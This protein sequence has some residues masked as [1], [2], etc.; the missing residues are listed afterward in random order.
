M[1]FGIIISC[2][3][4]NTAKADSLMPGYGE[5]IWT[6]TASTQEPPLLRGQSKQ[7]GPWQ[8]CTDCVLFL[9][10]VNIHKAIFAWGLLVTD[11]V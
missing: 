4:S 10:R 3:M 7:F 11:G 5:A 2:S 1:D 9:Q 8:R 6:S